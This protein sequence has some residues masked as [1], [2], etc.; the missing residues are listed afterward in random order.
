MLRAPKPDG[1]YRFCID[2]RRVNS[3]KNRY[4]PDN[5]IDQIGTASYIGE[6]DLMKGYCQVPLTHRARD[7]LCFVANNQ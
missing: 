2:Y 7:I 1:Q 5:C 3:D 6:I 4:L